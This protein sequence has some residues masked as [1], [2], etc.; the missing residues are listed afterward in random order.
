MPYCHKCGSNVGTRDAFCVRCG[1]AQPA[2][3]S[4]PGPDMLTGLSPRTA[5]LLCYIPVVG[6][7]AAIVILASTQYR[8]NARVRFDAFQ[9]IYL[10]VAWLVLEWV[11]GPLFHWPFGGPQVYRVI[12]ALMKAA[13]FGAWIFMIIK[14]SQEEQF[15]L[16]ILGELAEK[17]VTEQRT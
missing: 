17:S 3:A 2:A 11:V 6:W 15:K 8:H 4:P 9:G 10:F 13:V 7:L 16:P 12:P 14:A 1:T 5:S